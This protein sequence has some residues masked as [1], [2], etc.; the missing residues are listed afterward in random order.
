MSD[1]D[2]QISQF[3]GI[4]GVDD[5]R[6]RFYLESAAWNL[7]VMYFFIHFV[8]SFC[9]SYICLLLSPIVT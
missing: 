1:K 6:A 7:D 4:T 3:K 5:A 2:Q 9:I 8:A